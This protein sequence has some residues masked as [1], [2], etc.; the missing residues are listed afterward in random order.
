MIAHRSSAYA[1][2][3]MMLTLAAPGRAQAENR[4]PNVTPAAWTSASAPD[5]ALLRQEGAL[6]EKCRDGSGDDPATQR[7]CSA[8]DQ[9]V[10]TLKA[11]GWHFGTPD[12]IEADKQWTH[13]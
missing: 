4:I 7:A 2:C 9:A 11:R 12:Q 1:A 8:R 6:N 10:Q 13:P 3:L 5:R